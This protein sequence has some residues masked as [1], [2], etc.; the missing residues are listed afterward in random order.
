[1]RALIAANPAT[2]CS[3]RP[4][5]PPGSTMAAARARRARCA[6]SAGRAGRRR[7]GGLARISA[8]PRR[9][10]ISP[11]MSRCRRST[12]ASSPAPSRSRP[13]ARAT[14]QTEFGAVAHRPLADR[15]AFVARSRSPPGRACSARR[16][17]DKRLA[18][19][20]PDYPGARRPHR[21]CGRSRHAGERC[22]HRATSCA[23]PA[24][25]CGDC[26][27]GLADRRR[28]P[29]GRSRPTLTSPNTRPSSPRLPADV[30]AT[31][32][33]RRL[34]RAR[35]RSGLRRRHVPL[36][37]RAARQTDRRRAARPGR[38]AIAQGRLPRPRRCRRAT[39]MS[40]ST[41]G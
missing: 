21:L 10:P 14:R 37:L 6:G 40:L 31:P 8:R 38:P 2:S 22:R 27:R 33:S 20:L 15:V 5:F 19:V 24:M 35:R 4:R 36:P 23:L 11:C 7:R 17:R 12:V 32:S 3:T 25:T 18:C 9:P 1:M 13:R 30:P 16:R 39:P 26:R 28:S 29:K 34:G 41:S